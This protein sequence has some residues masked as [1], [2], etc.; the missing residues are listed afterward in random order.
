MAT[1]DTLQIVTEAPV[2]G[3]DVLPATRNYIATLLQPYVEVIAT[4]PIDRLAE[5]MTTVIPERL[6][7][8][9]L[10]KFDRY[11]RQQRTEYEIKKKVVELI[12]YL[13]IDPTTERVRIRYDESNQILPWDV[14]DTIRNERF[15]YLM[16][17]VPE[18]E[19]KLPVT[20]TI[21]GN[22]YTY[23]LGADFTA[24][25]LIASKLKIQP[26]IPSFDIV[27]FGA[28]LDD[29]FLKY[30]E[31][32]ENSIDYRRPRYTARYPNTFSKYGVELGVQG[33]IMDYEFNSPEFIQGFIT[34][35]QW[36]HLDYHAYLSNLVQYERV[37]DPKKHIYVA[38]PTPLEI[39]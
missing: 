37:K 14:Q 10:E 25:L 29:E 16:F 7:E 9:P 32:I 23:M 12:F 28:L 36:R 31:H 15:L 5:W 6:R 26:V 35:C 27:M 22:Q 33:E 8:E 11:M 38:K 1:L 17:H 3:Y 19:D 2:M 4:T 20:V 21:G 30:P 18:G 24:G 34:G 39:V 13:I